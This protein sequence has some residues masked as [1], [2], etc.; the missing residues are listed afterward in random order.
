MTKKHDYSSE[1]LNANTHGEL[2]QLA[3]LTGELAHE[4]KNPLSTVKI[5]L[6]LIAEQL[7]S[8]T[9]DDP[10][11]ARA[12]RKIAVVQ[13]ETNR[14]E[15][16]LDGFLKYVKRSDLDRVEADINEL[17]SDMIDFYSAQAHSHSITMR[18]TLCAEPLNARVDTV[19]IKQVL[20]N[21][22]LNAQQA[23]ESGGEL[24]IRTLRQGDRALIQISD[25][26]CGIEPEKNR[27]IFEPFYSSRPDGTGLGLPTARRIVEAHGGTIKVTSEPGKGTAFAIL[28]PL[29]GGGI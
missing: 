19:M 28:L 12:R 1:D 13:K 14:V 5:N 26:G 25:T 8:V 10:T 21:L 24:M 27:K 4:I 20:L 23:M 2:E 22:F 9:C 18:Q 15:K 3:K 17:V 29:A 16:I 11:L 7:D 6:K